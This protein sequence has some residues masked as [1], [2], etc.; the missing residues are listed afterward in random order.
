MVEVLREIDAPWIE[1]L[2]MRCAR[3]MALSMIEQ[4][5]NM[6]LEAGQENEL[7]GEV[8]EDMMA[9]EDENKVR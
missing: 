8:V 3:R 4:S 5:R 7:K 6:K 9:N 2:R 1:I